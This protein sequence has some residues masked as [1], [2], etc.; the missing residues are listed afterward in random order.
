M[1]GIESHYSAEELEQLREIHMDLICNHVLTYKNE[2]AFW[3]VRLGHV[4]S[5]PFSVV[6]RMVDDVF[7]DHQQS[8]HSRELFQKIGAYLADR[9][10]DNDAD[11]FRAVA[12][13]LEARRKGE[14]L[15]ELSPAELRLPRK[16]GRPKVFNDV[17]FVFIVALACITGHRA[18]TKDGG[19]YVGEFRPER[20]TREELL[21]EVTRWGGSLSDS[22]LSGMLTKYHF[23]RFMAEY[24]VSVKQQE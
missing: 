10:Q 18:R 7:D 2:A 1:S 4:A 20:I 19:A 13:I 15:R 23:N 17:S 5:H 8:S 14:S 6:L 12:A 9:I 16:R 21:S 11:Y 3:R 24:R 22:R